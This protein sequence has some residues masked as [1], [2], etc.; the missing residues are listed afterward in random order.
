MRNPCQ[1]R[2]H[3]AKGH[4]SRSARARRDARGVL[5]RENTSFII[6]RLSDNKPWLFLSQFVFPLT[7][8]Q[9]F[10]WYF[11]WRLLRMCCSAAAV[12]SIIHY[13]Q[14]TPFFH[15]FRN[16]YLSLLSE[17]ALAL[18]ASCVEFVSVTFF[19]FLALAFWFC[20]LQLLI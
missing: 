3:H 7:A 2:D 4:A 12:I 11:L 16:I 8:A 9:L 14:Q 5:K 18:E 10:I 6:S 15:P 13:F 20:L 1:A 19:C 17:T